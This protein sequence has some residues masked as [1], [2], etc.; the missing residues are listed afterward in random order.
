M[1]AVNCDCGIW[2]AIIDEEIFVTFVD[3]LS[4]FSFFFF[5]GSPNCFLSF[6]FI[7]L[8]FGKEEAPFAKI[9]RYILEF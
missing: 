4:S 6:D 2:G 1:T 5:S 9:I 3:F 7:H 8:L